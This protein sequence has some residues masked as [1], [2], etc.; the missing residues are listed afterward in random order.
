LIIKTLDVN[1]LPVQGSKDFS[2]SG[3][4]ST[5]KL[6]GS[7][8]YNL[9]CIFYVLSFTITKVNIFELAFIYCDRKNAKNTT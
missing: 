9:D 1:I 5:F 2:S 7:S 4:E 3:N 6:F 8:I